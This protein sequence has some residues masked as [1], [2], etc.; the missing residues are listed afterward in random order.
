MDEAAVARAYEQQAGAVYARCLRILRDRDAAR[1]VTQEVFVRCFGH[2][3]RLRDGGDGAELLAWLYRVA[4]NLC[5]NVVRD[6]DL[7]RRAHRDLPLPAPAAPVG[8]AG[9]EVRDLL[10]GL[11]RRTQEIVVYVYLDGM[12]HAE[13]ARV[14][15]VSDRTVRACLARFQQRGRLRFGNAAEPVLGEGS[16]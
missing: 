16:K 14:A 8:P 13:A 2:R 15:K 10:E 7:R 6:R 9:R 4:T 11:D 1:D 5:L 3:Q 12:T